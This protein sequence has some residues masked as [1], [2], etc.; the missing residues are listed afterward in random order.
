MPRPSTLLAIASAV[1]SPLFAHAANEPGKAGLDVTL[2]GA[3][4]VSGGAQHGQALHGLAWVHAD[5][6]QPEKSSNG[7]KYTGDISALGLAGKGP[8]EKIPVDFP[9]ASNKEDYPSARLDS[10]WGEARK[11]DWSLRGGALLAEEEFAGTDGSTAQRDAL[12]FLFR[13]NSSY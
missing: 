12:A 11:N 7:L 6:T 5:W 2:E 4:S 9:A 1:V 10:R 13:I 8:I 3:A